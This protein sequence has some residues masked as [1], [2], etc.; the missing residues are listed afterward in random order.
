M[1]NKVIFSL[2]L[3]ALLAATLIAMP[4][5]AQADWDYDR[6]GRHYAQKYS[7]HR[8]K[9]E[10]RQHRHGWNRGK[11]YYQHRHRRDHRVYSYPRFHYQPGITIWLRLN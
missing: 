5:M 4:T 10:Y 11:S 1:K 9:G 3:P 2:G 7:D 6:P 8:H